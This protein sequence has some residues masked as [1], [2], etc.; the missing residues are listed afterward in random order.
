MNNKFVRII[1]TMEVMT[2]NP[3]NPFNDKLLEYN[4]IRI[5]RLHEKISQIREGEQLEIYEK[6]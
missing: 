6:I 5:I 1:E 4:Q 2:G 3:W